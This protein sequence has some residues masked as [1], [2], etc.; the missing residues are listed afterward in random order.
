ML[1]RVS[2][3]GEVGPYGLALRYRENGQPECQW[4][5]IIKEPSKD[6]QTTFKVFVPMLTYG[7]RAEWAASTLEP[8]ML[9]ACDG[10]LAWR[11]NAKKPAEGKVD[12]KMVVMASS[13]NILLAP[14][15]SAN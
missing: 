7:E 5:C 3:V 6:G 9:V 13:V 1:N 8:G 14:V 11:A 15:A 10:K 4:T 2:L 12:G